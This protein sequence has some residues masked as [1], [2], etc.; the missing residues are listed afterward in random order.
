MSVVIPLAASS[1]DISNPYFKSAPL[2]APPRREDCLAPPPKISPKISPKASAKEMEQTRSYLRKRGFKVPGETKPDV[3]KM[4]P[5]KDKVTVNKTE[6]DKVA[7]PKPKTKLSLLDKARQFA[8]TDPVGALA[9]YDLGKGILGKI[10]KKARIP[11]VPTPR[12][13]RVSAK[14]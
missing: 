8:K 14:S 4:K 7:T 9:T 11:T 5:K 10:M 1:R 3:E 12:A 2:K 13:I 6:T